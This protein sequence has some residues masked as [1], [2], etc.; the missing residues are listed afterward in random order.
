[1]SRYSDHTTVGGQVIAHRFRMMK[2]NWRIIFMVGYFGGLAFF[3]GSMLYC[4]NLNEIWNYLCYLKASYR[5][6]FPWLPSTFLST[7][8]ILSDSGVW[9]LFADR[10][11]LLDKGMAVFSVSFEN[12]LFFNIKLSIGFAIFAMIAMLY[13]NKRLGKSL[14]DTKELLSGHDY[15]EGNKIKKYI[16]EKSDITLAEIPYPKDTECRH[17]ILTGTTGSG[18]TNVMIELLDQITAKNEKIV[19]VD[20]VG[21]YVDRYYKKDRDVILNPFSK[22][23]VSWSFLDECR[24]EDIAL[25]DALIKNVAACLVDSGARSNYDDFWDNAARIVFTETAKKAIRERKTTSEFLNILLKIKLD[26]IE[27]YLE[28]TYGHTLMDK[29]ADKMAISI[30][31]TL[32]NAVS[33]FE[34]LKEEKSDNFNSREWVSSDK[35]GILFLS[36]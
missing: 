32:I 27:K 21:T 5:V 33:V 17:T 29:R 2:Q 4:W 26:E 6:G 24:T 15:V 9:G 34:V 13:I 31:A 11:I 10:T 35:N 28:G 3:F 19:I 25:Q 30:R 1:M 16:K 23:Y 7:S 22:N 20:T 36:C 8:Y 12:S 14:S 18:K